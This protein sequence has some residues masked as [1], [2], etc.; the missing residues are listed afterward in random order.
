MEASKLKFVTHK[1][2]KEGWSYISTSDG[3]II[4]VKVV[5]TKVMKVLKSDGTPLSDPA[6]NPIYQFQSSNVINVLSQEEWNV[7]KR[8]EDIS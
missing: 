6:G 1:T 5:I 2:L 7:I 4:G 3:S 8:E